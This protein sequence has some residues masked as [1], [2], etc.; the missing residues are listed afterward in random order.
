LPPVRWNLTQPV[1]RRLSALGMHVSIDDYGTGYS[2]LSYLK[3]LP[4][5]ELKIDQSFI[6]GMGGG[7]F[8]AAIVA[9]TIGLGTSL[10]IDVVAEGVETEETL[11]VLTYLGCE[12]AQG[13]II[14]RP[15]TPDALISWLRDGRS[16]W[17]M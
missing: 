9:S 12:V 8:D 14:S 2:S 1:F 13:Y 10:G 7:G 17:H 11:Q 16:P 3:R 4:V 15:L 6:Q 5:N